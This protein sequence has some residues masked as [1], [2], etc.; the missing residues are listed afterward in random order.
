M[1][2]RLVR[3]GVEDWDGAF[4]TRHTLNEW[5]F[6]AFTAGDTGSVPGQWTKIPRALQCGPPPAPPKKTF[7]LQFVVT[8]WRHSTLDTITLFY[9]EMSRRACTGLQGVRRTWDKASA[10]T[11][12][13]DSVLRRQTPAPNNGTAMLSRIWSGFSPFALVGSSWILDG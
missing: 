9:W 4:S 6:G 5:A 13:A 12:P 7:A 3:P 10:L 11:V 2:L 1:R 8:D